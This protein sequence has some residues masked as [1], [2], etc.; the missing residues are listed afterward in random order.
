VREKYTIKYCQ[1]Y[2]KGKGGECLSLQYINTITRL[3][4]ECEFKHRWQA[5]FGNVK[6][7]DSWCPFCYG[8]VL[9][10][11]QDCHDWANSKGGCCFSTEYINTA[12]KMEW[13]CEYGHTWEAAFN[14]I[15]AGKWCPFCYGNVK[16]TLQD[17][18]NHAIGRGGKCLAAEYINVDTK[19]EWECEFFHRWEATFDKVKRGTWCPYCAGKHLTIEDCQESAKNENGKCL[20]DIYINTAT[21]MEWEC[22]KGHIWSSTFGRV[23]RRIWCPLCYKWKSQGKLLEII[24]IIYPEHKIY[25][26]HKG[27]GWL[28]N[29][30]RMEIDIW[31]PHLKLAIEY[32][33][34][35]HFEPVKFGGIS[36]EKAEGNFK[37][38]QRRDR[39]KN[40]LI[41]EHPEDINY[42]IRFKYDEPLDKEYIMKKI[43]NRIK[44]CQQK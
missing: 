43:A 11:L 3:E 32:D 38:T 29:K 26:N 34:E 4:W 21:K 28:K 14:N 35:Q 9:L 6:H 15:Q 2:A 36:D 10:T 19:I 20:S 12:T 16:L 17:C 5:S 30:M 31:V 25:N 7:K 41:K 44:Q 33:G 1:E 40:K 13:K 27:F 8:N 37:L 22:S 18:Q 42:F 23:R 24:Q 39:K